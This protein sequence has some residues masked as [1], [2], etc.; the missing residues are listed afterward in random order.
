MV[1]SNLFFGWL[2]EISA[3]RSHSVISACR[4]LTTNHCWRPI[5]LLT[6]LSFP[7]TDVVP[8][9]SCWHPQNLFL[10]D[11]FCKFLSTYVLVRFLPT[12]V[13]SRT[14]RLKKM[15]K[16]MW[17]YTMPE[18]VILKISFPHFRRRMTLL[19]EVIKKMRKKYISYY[20]IRLSLSHWRKWK[21][22]YCRSPEDDKTHKGVDY[23][24]TGMP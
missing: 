7:L 19:T 11:V 9:N 13:F 3:Y 5:N 18:W 10:P 17:V 12:E 14:S 8:S 15:W 22:A 16:H 24:K 4:H 6:P 23:R 1:I 21:L 2:V 20:T